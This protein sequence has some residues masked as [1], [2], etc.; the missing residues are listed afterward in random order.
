M[1]QWCDSAEDH[2]LVKVCRCARIAVRAAPLWL[3]LALTLQPNHYVP[4]L[5]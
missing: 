2:D 4:L 1:W 5:V 3:A